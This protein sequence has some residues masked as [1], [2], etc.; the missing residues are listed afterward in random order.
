MIRQAR[1]LTQQ[2]RSLTLQLVRFEKCAGCPKHC[3]EPLFDLFGLKKNTFTLSA[4]DPRYQLIDN[5]HKLSQTD[6]EGQLLSLSIDHND[7]LKSSALLYLLPL[8]ICLLCLMAGHYLG[9]V[10]GLN[11]DL[12]ALFGLLLGLGLVYVLSQAE[13]ISRSLKFRPKVTIL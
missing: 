12:F 13:F 4:N 11:N 7:L 3:N 2:P 6:L 10:A 1:V 8:L 9:S 5:R